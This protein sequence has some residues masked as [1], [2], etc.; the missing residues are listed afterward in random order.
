MDFARVKFLIYWL[1]PAHSCL[2]ATPGR[3][4]MTAA[5]SIAWPNRA[6]AEAKESSKRTPAQ[7]Q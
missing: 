2:S 4:V 3:W 1:S 7:M 5:A 6:R